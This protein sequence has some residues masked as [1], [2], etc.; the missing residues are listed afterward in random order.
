MQGTVEV[1][2]TEVAA[3]TTDVAEALEVQDMPAAPTHEAVKAESEEQEATL[4][5]A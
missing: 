2:Q 1:Q 3:E 5:A 4:V